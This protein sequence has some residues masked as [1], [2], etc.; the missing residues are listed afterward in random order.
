MQLTRLFIRAD[1][2]GHMIQKELTTAWAS[3]L[4]AHVWESQPIHAST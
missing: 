2:L 3:P 1:V 4:R